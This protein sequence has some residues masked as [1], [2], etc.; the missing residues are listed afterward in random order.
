VERRGRPR[1]AASGDALALETPALVFL[2]FIA[3]LNRSQ[4]VQKY[5]LEMAKAA[6]RAAKD[7]HEGVHAKQKKAAIGARS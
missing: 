6:V 5:L 4:I 2:F 3:A 1:S 7:K